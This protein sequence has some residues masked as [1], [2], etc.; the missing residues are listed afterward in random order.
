MQRTARR[1][2]LAATAVAVLVIATLGLLAWQLWSSGQ[3]EGASLRQHAEQRAG[4]IAASAATLVGA[5][6]RSVDFLLLEIRNTYGVDKAAFHA[7]VDRVVATFPEAPELLL[8]VSVAS[9]EGDL[10]YSTLGLTHK[11]NVA[12]RDA[13][14]AHLDGGDRL[15]ISDLVL[16]RISGMETIPF[17]RPVLRDGRFAGV[18]AVSLV[19]RQIGTLLGSFDSASDAE[20]ALLGRADAVLALSRDARHAALL[21]RK[22]PGIEPLVADADVA[23]GALRTG[24]FGDGAEHVVARQRVAGTDLAVVAALDWNAT[25]EPLTQRFRRAW[26]NTFA[27]GA[28]LLLLGAGVIALLLRMSRQQVAVAASEA[29]FRSLADRLQIGQSTA[30]RIVMDWHI[31]EDR[32]EWS[33]SPEWLRGPLPASGRYPL[34][35]DQVHPE[36]REGFLETRNR[37]VAT[38]VGEMQNYRLVRTDGEVLWL[39]SHQKVF[40][41]P[42]GKAQ[43]MIVAML[44]VTER[45]RIEQRVREQARLLDLIFRHS[46]DSIVLLDRDFNFLRVSA[47]YAKACQR[48]IA[49]FE[50]R[51]HFDL[52]PSDFQQEAE[53]ARDCKMIYHR[54]ARPFVFPDHPERGT[55]YWDIA[56]VPI[57]GADGEVELLLLTLKDVSEQV[58]TSTALRESAA[59]LRRLSHRLREVEERE[60]RAMARELHDRIGQNLSTLNLGLGML[61]QQIA[62]GQVDDAAEHLAEMQQTLIA[63][64]GHTRDLM[65]ELRPPALEEYGLLAAL[66]DLAA[67][68]GRK[69]RVAAGVEGSPLRPRPP[70]TIEIAMYR[71]A[72]EALNNA[73]KHAGATQVR[74]SLASSDDA[75]ELAVSDDGVGFDASQPGNGDPTW[76]LTTMRERAEEAGIELAIDSTPGRGTRI[77]LRAARQA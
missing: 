58:R 42:D 10:V 49:E 37:S 73:A 64:I 20:L 39:R 22:L 34:W 48:D 55:T 54:N 9:A 33:D 8:Q 3:S 4:Q 72:Q 59:R 29:R 36:D 32:L 41:G 16:G 67:D 46:I 76:G 25:R 66:Q 50:G 77:T 2:R 43:R 57:L 1:F 35:K 23:R 19:P 11:V 38:G 7:L 53:R 75:V 14:K 21:G 15:H 13:F 61:G 60:R 17:T 51:N 63:V 68:F 31:A 69:T 30:R 45:R 44:D 74:L 65:S 6:V 52:Y 24:V 27:F 71:I 26:T 70:G 12:D 40:A 5:M 56:L 18:V 62:A 47:S 28:A